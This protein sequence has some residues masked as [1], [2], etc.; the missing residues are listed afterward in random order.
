MKRLTQISKKNYLTLKP[1]STTMG[2][3][4][5]I[6]KRLKIKRLGHEI[7]KQAIKK[8]RKKKL[9]KRKLYAKKLRKKKRI[10]TLPRML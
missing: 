6:K 8:L 4:Q 2:Q 10:Y 7:N 1:R 3:L 9:F 5:K